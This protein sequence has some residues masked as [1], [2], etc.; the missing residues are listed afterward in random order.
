[1]DVASTEYK[2]GAEIALNKKGDKYSS[3]RKEIS[4][5]VVMAENDKTNN[6]SKVIIEETVNKRLAK[7]ILELIGINVEGWKVTLAAGDVRHILNRHGKRGAADNS[8]SDYENFEDI[9]I[10]NSNYEK[11]YYEGNTSTKYK[12]KDR[13]PAKIVSLRMPY[14]EGYMYVSEAVPESKTKTI[15][16][17]TV[18]LNKNK[19]L[20]QG[21]NEKSPKHNVQNGLASSTLLDS[22]LIRNNENI[23]SEKIQ[24]KRD[25]DTENSDIDKEFSLKKSVEETKNLIALHNLTPTNL[26]KNLKLGIPVHEYAYGNE[27]QRKNILNN[28]DDVKFALSKNLSDDL[29]KILN[30]EV[31]ASKT[32]LLI[33]TT[34]RVLAKI[35][36]AENYKVTMS[37]GKAYSAMVDRKTAENSK[38]YR[39]AFNYHNLGKEKVIEVLEKSEDPIM[40]INPI[41][42][43]KG[44]LP[45]RLMVITDILDA[46]GNNIIVIQ[47]VNKKGLL[48]KKRIK[49]IKS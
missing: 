24:R 48:Y 15:H 7:D 32:E 26:I 10:I 39:E 5:L 18:Y 33:G 47:D 21:L 34:S 27:E 9:P 2:N 45:D 30:Q 8:M 49:V 4:N 23:N 35:L 16:I 12:N 17:V 22:R 25:S 1:M 44:R 37:V 29:D 41:S 38:Y 14:K 36:G 20:P 19:A 43:N 40:I 46:K 28:L 42:E 6:W 13:S 31:D 3:L 11:A